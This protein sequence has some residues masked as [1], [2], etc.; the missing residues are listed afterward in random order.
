MATLT[1]AHQLVATQDME[2]Q[3]DDSLLSL[4]LFRC[5]SLPF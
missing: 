3:S 1:T 4:A 2:L 5:K